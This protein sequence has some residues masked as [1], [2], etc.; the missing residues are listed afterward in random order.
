ML[1][2][3]IVKALEGTDILKYRMKLCTAIF[4]AGVILPTKGDGGYYRGMKHALYLLDEM[5]RQEFEKV[6]SNFKSQILN[7]NIAKYRKILLESMAAH[8]AM[9]NQSEYDYAFREGM[10]NA[11][12][13]L[14][15]FCITE[16]KKACIEA[17]NK[18]Y[19]GLNK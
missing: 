2:N 4:A 19:G 6:I 18:E 14:D 16:F 8:R 7:A 12:S 15:V 13:I 3:T 1:S 9:V 10:Y 5:C 11:L 17:I